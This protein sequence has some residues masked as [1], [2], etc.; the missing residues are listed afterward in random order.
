MII[1]SL[2]TST[3]KTGLAVF[4]NCK[5]SEYD[6]IDLSHISNTSIRVRNM[7]STLWETL[8]KCK[9]DCIVIEE[10]KVTRNLHTVKLLSYV[11]S[12]AYLYSV[13]HQI[14]YYEIS[15][16]MWRGVIGIQKNKAKRA[17]LKALSVQYVLEHFGLAVNDD[18]SDAICIGTAFLNQRRNNDENNKSKN[19]K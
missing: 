4:K 6:C 1:V 15:P 7:A 8:Q 13:I 2:D 17:E 9:P 19:K 14:E 10:L 16:A 18:I 3:K 11:I 12:T 5:L